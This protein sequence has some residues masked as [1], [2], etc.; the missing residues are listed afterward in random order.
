[1]RILFIAF[2]VLCNSAQAQLYERVDKLTGHTTYTNL[3]PPGMEPARSDI[4]A[5]ARTMRTA[6]KQYVPAKAHNAD[7]NAAAEIVAPADFPKISATVQKERDNNRR[8]ILL[9]EL[10][11]EF[12]TLE[13]AQS[14]KADADTIN[15]HK[16]NIASLKRE[17]QTIK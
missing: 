16:T 11:K 12:A 2:F 3:P 14:K 10:N 15:R 13:D 9:D 6:T 5:P 7:A 1:M 17:I 8:H 4:P